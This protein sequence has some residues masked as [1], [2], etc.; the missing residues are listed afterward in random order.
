MD[1]TAVI[2]LSTGKE[3][4]LALLTRIACTTYPLF[5]NSHGK[6]LF[7]LFSLTEDEKTELTEL[8]V[9]STLDRPPGDRT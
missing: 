1:K 3:I 2:T 6:D 5:K 4:D 7:D 8:I 9:G